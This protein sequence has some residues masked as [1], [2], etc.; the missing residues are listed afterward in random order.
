MIPDIIIVLDIVL[1]VGANFAIAIG[2][3]GLL[4]VPD[5]LLATSFNLNNLNKYNFP[6]EDNVS[7]SCSNYFSFLNHNNYSFNQTIFDQVLSFCYNDHM[8]I[9]TNLT[10]SINYYR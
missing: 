5:N 1:N 9:Y 8:I 3:V 6:I 2:G 4:S 7:L 10:S